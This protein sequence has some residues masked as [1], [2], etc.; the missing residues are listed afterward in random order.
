MSDISAAYLWRCGNS[1]YTLLVVIRFPL[2]S[3][4]KVAV[5]RHA[6][7]LVV[8]T[9]AAVFAAS[10]AADARKRFKKPSPA[11]VLG[12]L[13]LPLKLLTH[14]APAP[15]ASRVRSSRSYAARNRARSE[16]NAQPAAT[17][18]AVATTAVATTAVA[19]PTETTAAVTPTATTAMAAPAPAMQAAAA[20]PATPFNA[21]EDILGYA[22]WPN[23]YAKRFW[24]RGYGDIMTS[25]MSPAA[26]AA[27]A[28][29][30]DE[31]RG[32]RLASARSGA[33]ATGSVTVAGMCGPQAAD[34]VNGPIDRIERTLELNAGQQLK[35]ETLRAAAFEAVER[36]QAACRDAL[37][38]TP[39][40]RLQ[41]MLDALWAMRDADILFR[42]PL[43]V[44]YRSLTDVQKARLARGLQDATTSGPPPGG[45]VC[46]P[47]ANDLPLDAIARSA[48]PTPEQ[49]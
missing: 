20:A 22:L 7:L 48:A 10:T 40:D 2:W 37:P 19:A 5:M 39:S 31:R 6:T 45:P 8:A 36:G 24:S 33:E 25:V 49:R 15:R 16:A 26:L 12:I 3:T 38:L 28:A 29:Q 27:A 47:A 9:V 4:V 30:V 46:S 43:D 41:A 23:D 34:H 42:T 1:W 18:A 32:R 17:G 44:F 35:L 13:S 11:P 14:G 21:Y